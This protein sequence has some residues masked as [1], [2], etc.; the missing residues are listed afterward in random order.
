[1]PSLS[2]SIIANVEESYISTY[3][4]R[5]GYTQPR[6]QK[7]QALKYWVDDLLKKQKINIVEF[8]DFLFNELFWGKR[9]T[10]RMYRLEKVKDYKYPEDWESPLN[11]YYGFNSIDFC[12]ILNTI[13]SEKEPR[14]IAAIRSE[15]NNKG[16]LVKIRLLFVFYIEIDEERRIKSSTA[17]I[18]IDIDFCKKIM[19]I[20]AWT[21]QGIAFDEYKAEKLIQRVKKLLETEFNVTTRPYGMAHKEILF[22]MS[23]SLIYEAYSSVPAYNKIGD[24]ENSIKSFIKEAYSGL[25]L[26][27]IM[28]DD[29][30]EQFLPQGVLDFKGEIRNVLENLVISDYFFNRSY[31]EIWEAGLEAIISRIKFNDKEEVLT[32]LN[33]ENTEAPIFCTKTFMSLKNRMEETK[34]IETLWIAMD[35]ENGQKGHL[36]LKFDASDQEYLGI[37]IANYGIRFNEADM[38]STLRIYGKYEEEFT[39]KDTGK[40]KRA[41]GQ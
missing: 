38:N 30:G 16:E 5:K 12:D 10:I 36:N 24:I 17:Y 8:E 6:E 34:R 32:S 14:K 3:L 33:A 19:L 25:P 26:R 27:N 35:R 23:R 21:R 31:N 1:M 37:L 11:K 13:P 15:E 22:N 20:K 40:G 4:R 9:K 29:D 18:P 7:G 41:V 28:E 2:E 39:Q